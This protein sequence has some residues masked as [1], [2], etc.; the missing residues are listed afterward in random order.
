MKAYTLTKHGKPSVLKIAEVLDPHPNIG[1]IRIKI[2]KI[3]INYA[4]ILSRKGMYGWAPKLPYTL[5]MEAFGEIDS[6]GEGVTHSQIGE[7]VIVGTQFG[8]YA[9]KIVVKERQVLPVIKSFSSEENAAFAVNYLTA[10]VSLFEMARIR[11]TDSILIQAA[12][13]GVGT[14]AVQLAKHFG[15]TVFGTASRDEKIKLLSNLNI[16]GAV[17]YRTQDF[18]NEI[19]RFTGGNGVDVILEVVGGEVYKKSLR[20]LNPLGRIVIVGFA[21]MN[22]Q[23]WN[24][25]SWLKTWRDM[26]KASIMKMSEKSY[27][28]MATHLGYLLPDEKQ[29]KRTWKELCTFVEAHDIKPL[30]GHTFD[31][32]EI[33][34]AHEL[35]ESRSSH[36][37]I[38]INVS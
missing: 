38:V 32:D 21:S 6:L 29:L 8:S 16:D 11:P 33:I 15:C 3:G 9:E 30:V 37:K 26:P 1:E 28:V 25:I 23:K 5:G 31:F 7:Q 17:N 18:E 14:A 22:F 2:K 12:A 36:G 34:K 13:G 19:K 10:W 24:P 4:E 20:L 35:M 27:G